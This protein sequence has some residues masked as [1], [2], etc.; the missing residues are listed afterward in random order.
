MK[1]IVLLP[2]DDRPC[3]YLYPQLLVSGEYVLAMP[4]KDILGNKKIPGDIKAISNW[5]IKESKDADAIIISLDMLL[6][7][8]IVPSRL[9]Y[10]S[11]EE[12][13]KNCDI[14]PAIRKLNSHAKIY[15]FELI[16]R[17]PSYSSDDEEPDYYKD[18]G[19][20]IFEYGRLTHL[21]SLNKL[22]EEDK[23]EFNNIKARLPQKYLNDYVNRRYINTNVLIH[24][25]SYLKEDIVD[26]FIIPQDDAS[27]YGFT[28]ID[29]AKVRSYLKDNYLHYK[30]AMYPS[31]DDIGLTLLA[32]AISELS[33]KQNKVFVKYIS[34]EAP[35]VIPWFE[36][37][38]L[39]ETIKFHLLASNSLRVYSLEE[40][41]IVLIVTMGS[42]MV[43]FDDPE[44]DKHYLINR[45]VSEMVDYIKYAKANGKLVSIGDNST[46]NGSD[47]LIFDALYQNNLLFKIDAY[48][49]WNT[50]SNTLGTTLAQVII[51]NIIGDNKKNQEFLSYR[52]LEDMAYMSYVRGYVTNNILP[53]LGYDYFKVDGVDGKVAAKVKEEILKY[54]NAN[55]PLLLKGIKDISVYQPWSRMFETEIHIEFKE[56]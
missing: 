23:E 9:H 12:V 22:T 37:R 8:G 45:S 43:N 4:S 21:E 50:S 40:A 52:Y 35:F 46:C 6:F 34:N 42:K 56:I 38:P 16:M 15:L 13:I 3:N 53:S 28:S 24:N 11:Y 5:L 7:G 51:Y 26:Y 48:A 44:F 33:N 31:A 49:G 14:I 47:K 27:E 30:S 1:K 36:D 55:Y 41:D 17:C 10:M 20:D 29:Q 32:R 2:L 39:D 18:F 25:L 54:V 19:F